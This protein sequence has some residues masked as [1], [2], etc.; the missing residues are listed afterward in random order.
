MSHLICTVTLLTHCRYL[1]V[2]L[3]EYHEQIWT[4]KIN[5]VIYLLCGCVLRIYIYTYVNV[6]L[7]SDSYTSTQCLQPEVPNYPY[8]HYNT[9]VERY[10]PYIKLLLR[11][12]W[13]AFYPKRP[14]NAFQF[15]FNRGYLKAKMLNILQHKLYY[16]E[17]K[18]IH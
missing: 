10:L 17:A 3:S 6:Y 2:L 1:I 16:Y 14:F 15:S 11:R 13:Q 4:R 8:T 12:N 5:Q 7:Y 18:I 9:H